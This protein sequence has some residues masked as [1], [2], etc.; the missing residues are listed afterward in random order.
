MNE[1]K[2]SFTREEIKTIKPL[3]QIVRQMEIGYDKFDYNAFITLIN[4][5]MSGVDNAKAIASHESKRITEIN[6][7]LS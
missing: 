5:L 4:V 1:I 2:S 7:I 6:K 3:A